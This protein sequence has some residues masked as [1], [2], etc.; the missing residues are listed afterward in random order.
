MLADSLYKSVGYK[1]STDFFQSVFHTEQWKPIAAIVSTLTA[2]AAFCEAML[3]IKALVIFAI[4]VLYS[5]ELFTGIKASIKEG[6]PFN[7]KKFPRG[8]VKLFI[9]FSLIFCANI[10]NM[11]ILILII[12]VGFIMV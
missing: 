4:I 9:Y 10:Y 2:I 8:W 7:S 5:L 1:D 3:G 11:E 12:I 6:E